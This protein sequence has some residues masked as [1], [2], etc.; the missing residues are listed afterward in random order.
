M[1]R[2][3]GSLEVWSSGGLS[4]CNAWA[5]FVAEL[6]LQTMQA[7][8]LQPMGS[9][10][11]GSVFVACRLSSCGGWAL[12]LWCIS[13]LALQHMESQFPKQR[14]NLYSL[15]YIGKQIL[16][17]WATRD[18]YRYCVCECLHAKS[19]QLRLTPWDPMDHSPPGS[20]VH[21]IIQARIWKW[22][23]MPSSRGS[24]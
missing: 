9:R 11:H 24:S 12:Q 7:Q 4:S 17:H 22:V 18:Y 14:S 1:L 5:S 6:R 19:L 15:A 13:L 21:E 3:M 23:T 10:V 16:N 8:Q 2:Y 20:S